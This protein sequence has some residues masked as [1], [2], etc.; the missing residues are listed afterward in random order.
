VKS[1]PIFARAWDHVVRLGG[2]TERDNRSELVRGLVGMVLEIGAGTGLNLALYERGAR[3]VAVE[4]EP[5]MVRTAAG[6]ARRA[7]A[8]ATVLRGVAENLPFREETF[9][10]VVACYVLCSVDDPPRALAELRRVL[11]P[12]GEV[13]VCGQLRI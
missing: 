2:R 10:A 7:A 13:R 4:P 11:R 12:G 3:V 6:R 5:N 9:D 8:S 1:H